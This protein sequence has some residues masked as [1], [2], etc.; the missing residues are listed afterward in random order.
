[1]KT[2]Y[3]LCK[4]FEKQGGDD[5]TLKS[6]KEIV[7]IAFVEANDKCQRLISAYSFVKL[8][9]CIHIHTH[10]HTFIYIYIYI[11]IHDVYIH[12]YIHL[13]IYFFRY[14]CPHC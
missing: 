3:K 2:D 4:P 8:Y 9:I 11:Y 10:T 6:C 5:G 7:D 12:M 1:M 14:D 13:V